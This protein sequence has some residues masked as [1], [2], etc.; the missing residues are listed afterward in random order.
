MK[1]LVGCIILTAALIAFSAYAKVYSQGK[2]ADIQEQVAKAQ[3]GYT[4]ENYDE[5]VSCARTAKKMWSG[6]AE[7]TLFVDCPEID[8]EITITLARIE[9]YVEN[10]DDELYPECAAAMN[11]LDNYSDRQELTWVN[12]F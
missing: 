7:D 5:A 11:L 1:R 9:E 8:V 4:D 2:M 6:L 12:I 3:A 10:R